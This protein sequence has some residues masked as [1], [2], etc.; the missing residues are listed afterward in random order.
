MGSPTNAFGVFSGER[1]LDA[2]RIKLGRDA[3]RIGANHYIFHGQYY[4]QIIAAE[5]TEELQQACWE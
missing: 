5:D 3:Y 4:I 1:P 2:Q